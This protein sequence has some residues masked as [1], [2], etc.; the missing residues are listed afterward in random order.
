MRALI[1]SILV[2]SLG[3]VLTASGITQALPDPSGHWEGTLQVP[4]TEMKVEVDL[5]KNGTGAFEGTF[6]Q[7]LQGIKGLPL[8]TVTVEDKRVRFV[9]R[10]GEGTRDVRGSSFRRRDVDRGDGRTRWSHD[11]FHA[12]SQRRRQ[13]RTA[14][15]QRPDRQR[16]GRLL[17]RRARRQWAL[18]ARGAD[19][20]Q[21][22]KRDCDRDDHESRRQRDR[23]SNRDDTEGFERD[24]RCA[25]DWCVIRGH[26]EPGG[27]GA[28]WTMDARSRDGS[29]DVPALEIVTTV[30]SSKRNALKRSATR[31]SRFCNV[32]AKNSS[33][34]VPS[35]GSRCASW[36]TG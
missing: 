2:G 16:V 26:A 18:D 13:D 25:I 1:Q 14:A 9:V 6:G 36:A 27:H 8:S 5:R 32:Q 21:S 3:L 29:V 34:S 23:D 28:R 22:P 33:C 31:R 11:P 30:H 10:A 35:D 20:D 19:D 17:E 7:P 15:R 4:G 12:D 24:D